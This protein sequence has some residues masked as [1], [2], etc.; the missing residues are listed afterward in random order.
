MTSVV[1]RF[2]LQAAIS[3]PVARRLGASYTQLGV[4]RISVDDAATSIAVE[5][6]A[7]RMDA[8]GV[9]ALLRR[10]AVPIGEPLQS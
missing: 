10:F 5:Y 6:D 7:T 2:S 1:V 4:R 8:P 3:D 9:A